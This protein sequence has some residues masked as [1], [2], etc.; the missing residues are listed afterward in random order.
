MNIEPKIAN[1]NQIYN[2]ETFETFLGHSMTNA[3]W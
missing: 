2:W 1:E 3:V